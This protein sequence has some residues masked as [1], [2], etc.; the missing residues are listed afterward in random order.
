MGGNKRKRR[1]S[2][3][4]ARTKTTDM[5]QEAWLSFTKIL[6]FLLFPYVYLSLLR[7]IRKNTK[8]YQKCF[9]WA[10]L[11]NKKCKQKIIRHV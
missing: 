5:I 3:A 2:E 7:F 10:T 11:I 8:C 9:R 1:A 4:I 6:H